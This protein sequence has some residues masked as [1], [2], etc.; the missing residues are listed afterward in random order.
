[1]ITHVALSPQGGHTGT[2]G[3]WQAGH[4]FSLLLQTHIGIPVSCV[5][6]KPSGSQLTPSQPLSQAG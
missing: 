1:M 4:L 5:T 6:Q 2:E 3:S